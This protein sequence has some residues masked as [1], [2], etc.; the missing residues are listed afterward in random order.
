MKPYTQLVQFAFPLMVHL[1]SKVAE[2]SIEGTNQEQIVKLADSE[3]CNFV[4]SCLKFF[5]EFTMDIDEL[6]LG[7]ESAKQ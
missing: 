7:H 3:L 6:K 4:G 5:F 1:F 2:E